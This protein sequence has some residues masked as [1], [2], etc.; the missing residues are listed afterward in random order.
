MKLR[1]PFSPFLFLLLSAGLWHCDSADRY[2]SLTLEIIW[3]QTGSQSFRPQG[4]RPQALPMGVVALRVEITGPDMGKKTQKFEDLEPAG[5]SIVVT[6]V[7]A[8]DDRTITLDGLDAGD[9]VCFRG[10]K[11][12]ITVLADQNNECGTILMKPH[13]E[14]AVQVQSMIDQGKAQLAEYNYS[15]AHTTFWTVLEDYDDQNRE[16]MFGVVLADILETLSTID[17]K[18]DASLGPLFDAIGGGGAGAPSSRF[19]PQAKSGLNLVIESLIDQ[20]LMDTLDTI[21]PLMDRIKNDPDFNMVIESVPLLVGTEDSM[22]SN[23]NIGGEFDPGDVYLLSAMCRYIRGNIKIL[24]ATDLTLNPPTIYG[25]LGDFFPGLRGE[26]GESIDRDFYT[27]LAAFII[28]TS[29]NFLALEPNDGRDNLSAAADDFLQ[30]NDDLFN[31]LESIRAET[32]DQTDDFAAYQVKGDKQYMTLQYRDRDGVPVELP[33]EFSDDVFLAFENQ[34]A[35]TQAAGGVR[36]NFVND[37]VP[38]QALLFQ[39]IGQA[40]GFETVADFALPMLEEYIGTETVEMVQ[41]MF[42]TLASMAAGGILAG[43]Y[44]LW[45]P[46]VL[47]LDFGK[48][49]H[50]PPDELFRLLLPDLVTENDGSQNL[51]YEYEC[52]ETLRPIDAMCRFPEGITSSSH[53][54]GA[55]FLDD[56]G[57]DSPLPYYTCADPSMGGIAYLNLHLLDP[58]EFPDEFHPPS[59]YEYNYFFA[60]VIGE[61]LSSFGIE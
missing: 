59:Q 31:C 19:A 38:F 13:G 51:R 21:I 46:D 14:L 45:I 4:I 25:L 7:P 37:I 17:E 54:S 43:G 22:L 57:I 52:P 55:D 6:G 40:G 12:G 23:G 27:K 5:G 47:E 34:K 49:Y 18:L 29:P 16:A 10:T 30:A 28:H 53:F 42:D 9:D 3:D 32:D 15:G 35:S 24:Y 11:T 60:G 33:V 58:D 20:M 44:T 2:G 8:G 39:G 36:A 48:L 56:D 61:L 50:D 1:H 41:G 26:T